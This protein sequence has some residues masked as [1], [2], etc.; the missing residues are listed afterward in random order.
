MLW[1]KKCCEGNGYVNAGV[2][3]V[4]GGGWLGWLAGGVLLVG[5][6]SVSVVII[7]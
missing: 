5:D 1:F 3:C 4:D 2:G 7:V 6:V